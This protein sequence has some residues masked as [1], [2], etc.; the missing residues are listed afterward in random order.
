MIAHGQ[1]LASA[2]TT[3]QATINAALAQ[4]RAVVANEPRMLELVA[5]LIERDFACCRSKCEGVPC[6]EGTWPT[7][8]VHE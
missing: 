4:Y 7:I 5:R 3:M 8:P 6:P 1:A 2:R